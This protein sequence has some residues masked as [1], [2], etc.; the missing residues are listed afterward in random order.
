VVRPW[1]QPGLISLPSGAMVP[2]LY[3]PQI[4]FVTGGLPRVAGPHWGICLGAE[5][6]PDPADYE[7]Q[8]AAA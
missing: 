1:G 8:H 5:A 4:E 3:G 7:T 6:M 2:A